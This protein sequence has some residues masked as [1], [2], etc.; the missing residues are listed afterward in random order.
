MFHS[1]QS[2]AKAHTV[3]YI[4]LT[5]ICSATDMKDLAEGTSHFGSNFFFFNWI[6]TLQTS[7]SIV[8]TAGLINGSVSQRTNTPGTSHRCMRFWLRAEG[9]YRFKAYHF[10]VFL[11]KWD[12]ILFHWIKYLIIEACWGSTFMKVHQYANCFAMLVMYSNKKEK[13]Q[14]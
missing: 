2:Q 5:K 4:N 11:H 13:P 9:C 3:Q 8:I 12:Q 6:W 14:T 10:Q 1:R 7:S